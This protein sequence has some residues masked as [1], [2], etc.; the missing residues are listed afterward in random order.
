MRDLE[1]EPID[2]NPTLE[3]TLTKS[4][5]S[6]PKNARKDSTDIDASM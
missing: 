5:T 4:Q 2:N 6:T 3:A 1:K